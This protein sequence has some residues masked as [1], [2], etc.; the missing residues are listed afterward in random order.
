MR[1][2]L[3]RFWAFRM[4][5]Q[6]LIGS[7][8]ILMRFNGHHLAIVLHY[9][10]V[11]L[12]RIRRLVGMPDIS[13]TR[14]NQ[15]QTVLVGRYQMNVHCLK[16]SLQHLLILRLMV[17]VGNLHRR[18]HLCSDLVIVLDFILIRR[19]YIQLLDNSIDL[20][21]IR[22]GHFWLVRFV[23]LVGQD[24]QICQFNFSW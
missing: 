11:W 4:L 14:F 12:Y 21:G 24:I 1:V 15:G 2:L 18:R 17:V 8:G 23:A 13:A 10:S 3:F 20:Y 19:P 9:E 7:I 22:F 5:A 6:V 16:V